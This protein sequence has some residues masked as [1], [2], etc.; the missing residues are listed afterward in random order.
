[1]K[2]SA[3]SADPAASAS[4]LDFH[5]RPSGFGRGIELWGATGAGLSAWLNTPPLQEEKTI[6]GTVVVIYSALCNYRSSIL[7]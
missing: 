2:S 5:S 3:L 6:K 1:M 4:K 7:E